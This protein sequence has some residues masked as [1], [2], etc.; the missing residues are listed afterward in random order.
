MPTFI[1]YVDLGLCKKPPVVVIDQ[2]ATPRKESGL[3]GRLHKSQSQESSQSREHRN[4]Y[5]LLFLEHI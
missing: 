5:I 2:D 4:Y 3:Q 1:H